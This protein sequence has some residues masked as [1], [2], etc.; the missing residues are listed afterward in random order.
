MTTIGEVTTK[1]NLGSHSRDEVLD[2]SDA[3]PD[4][5]PGLPYS[6]SNKP[7][8]SREVRFDIVVIGLLGLLGSIKP[9]MWQVQIKACHR[10][11]ND[12]VLNRQWWGLPH[13]NL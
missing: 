7:P 6:P 2:P 5:H 12:A 4:R 3:R 1:S 9:N 8:Q 10:G 11:Q 13:W